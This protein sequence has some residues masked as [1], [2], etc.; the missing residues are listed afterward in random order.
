M[1]EEVQDEERGR[2][3]RGRPP[4]R[5]TAS[6]SLREKK[7]KLESSS[8]RDESEREGGEQSSAS[9]RSREDTMAVAADRSASERGRRASSFSADEDGK[10]AVSQQAS[11]G[12]E[13]REKDRTSSASAGSP[14]AEAPSTEKGQDAGADSTRDEEARK[15]RRERK[16]EKRRQEM[17]AAESL[18]EPDGPK[19]YAFREKRQKRERFEADIAAKKS[20]TAVP[21]GFQ[22]S[23]LEISPDQ[24]QGLQLFVYRKKRKARDERKLGTSGEAGAGGGFERQASTNGDVGGGSGPRGRLGSVGTGTGSEGG[25][26]EGEALPE[27]LQ[28]GSKSSFTLGSLDQSGS[29]DRRYRKKKRGGPGRPRIH[30]IP[31]PAGGALSHHTALGTR[32]VKKLLPNPKLGPKGEGRTASQDRVSGL[33]EETSA[34]GLEADKAPCGRKGAAEA[35]KA[36]GD[37]K[38]ATL[39]DGSRGSKRASVASTGKK[40][41]GKTK[42]SDG[43]D[44]DLE[45]G[46]EV[47]PISEESARMIREQFFQD[48]AAIEEYLP[49]GLYYGDS[50]AEDRD[51]LARQEEAQKARYLEAK[52][53]F[54]REMFQRLF[55]ASAIREESEKAQQARS[56]GGRESGTNEASQSSPRA[57]GGEVD[58]ERKRPDAAESEEKDEHRRKGSK[59]EGSDCASPVKSRAR[60]AS[61]DAERER[62]PEREDRERSK[63]SSSA[64]EA[65]DSLVSPNRTRER[66]RS[67]ASRQSVA[68]ALRSPSDSLA[69]ESLTEQPVRSPSASSSRRASPGRRAKAEADSACED[70]TAQSAS[71]HEG[72]AA[73]RPGSDGSSS[74]ETD[75]AEKEGELVQKRGRSST[76]GGE[77]PARCVESQPQDTDSRAETNKENKAAGQSRAPY[78]LMPFPS[79]APTA[80][81][82]FSEVLA[83][84]TCKED[85]ET[86]RQA[87]KSLQA[88]AASLMR[89]V[90]HLAESRPFVSR[91]GASAVAF[92]GPTGRQK[93]ARGEDA[94]CPSGDSRSVCPGGRPLGA[95]LSSALLRA[96]Q[97]EAESMEPAMFAVA[98]S[99]SHLLRAYPPSILYEDLP[100]RL[101]LSPA[102][103]ASLARED[104]DTQE[105]THA[106]ERAA[107]PE[108]DAGVSAPGEKGARVKETD[109]QKDEEGKPRDRKSVRPVGSESARGTT[110]T[111]QASGV[112]KEGDAREE[113]AHVT[114]AQAPRGPLADAPRRRFASEKR[115]CFNSLTFAHAPLR[116]FRCWASPPGP[117]GL[118]PPSRPVSW[119]RVRAL[120]RA[121]GTRRLARLHAE[122]QQQGVFY[123]PPSGEWEALSVIHPVFWGTR[124]EGR[125]RA[126]LL[127]SAEDEETDSCDCS[128]EEG[129]GA[130][131]VGASSS[132][133]KTPGKGPASPGAV[134]DP[135]E[136]AVASPLAALAS[137]GSSGGGGLGSVKEG[138]SLESAALPSL[139]HASTVSASGS[140]GPSGG[141]STPSTTASGAAKAI[142]ALPASLPAG[143]CQPFLAARATLQARQEEKRLALPPPLPLRPHCLSADLEAIEKAL[144]S[145]AGG[146]HV[147]SSGE[148]HWRRVDRVL[149]AFHFS[150]VAQAKASPSGKGEDRREAK[151]D[152]MAFDASVLPGNFKTLLEP[153]HFF[154]SEQDLET[155]AQLLDQARALGSALASQSAGT[156]SLKAGAGD[157]AHGKAGSKASPQGGPH[158]GGAASRGGGLQGS[159]T[160]ASGD[161]TGKARSKKRPGTA[162]AFGPAVSAEER[163]SEDRR[164]SPGAFSGPFASGAGDGEKGRKEASVGGGEKTTLM[165]S[166]AS[167]KKLHTDAANNPEV[168]AD[169]RQLLLWRWRKEG[170]SPGPA[171]GPVAVA[172]A[173]D[174]GPGTG[175]EETPDAQEGKERSLEGE[176][177]PDADRENGDVEGRAAETHAKSDSGK[178]RPLPGDADRKE[179]RDGLRE[180]ESGKRR[181]HEEEKR[182]GKRLAAQTGRASTR[183]AGTDFGDNEGDETPTS[184][185]AAT[186]VA[187]GSTVGTAS[188]ELEG[189]KVLGRDKPAGA[190]QGDARPRRNAARS[191][192]ADVLTAVKGGN[193]AGLSGA[194][195]GQ[196]GTPSSSAPG[197]SSPPA[198]SVSSASLPSALSASPA[199]SPST[200]ASASWGQSPF[201]KAQGT[202]SSLGSSSPGALGAAGES[203]AAVALAGVAPGA[204]PLKCLLRLLRHYPLS[205]LAQRLGVHRSTVARWAKMWTRQQIEE[206]GDDDEDEG[207]APVASSASSVRGHADL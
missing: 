166:A 57:L 51:L 153:L 78:S 1:K 59:E 115:L 199:L 79:Q 14:D 96:V 196:A 48:A 100:P 202:V 38:K 156:K 35:H 20:Y 27:T 73:G 103:V 22:L 205:V 195:T 99:L 141:V 34:S 33:R 204:P 24:V 108:E 102:A 62:S 7:E 171:F 29:R 56:E 61:H 111:N 68:S 148:R 151:D 203:A 197:A 17:L 98:S 75:F 80:E 112:E 159:P 128:E 168:E 188:M 90:T 191:R 193:H 127:F 177:E 110:S 123:A 200:S 85:I 15:A 49:F 87:T 173:P 60:E 172:T 106:K 84:E 58:L 3:S 64:D 174:E 21:T 28:S 182:D 13:T 40:R 149:N 37:K 66:R 137:G 89:A 169:I 150:Q 25:E 9:P 74:K 39:A 178:K 138:T 179:E 2:P 183:Q 94:S 190:G 109:T 139:S 65:E 201:S 93:Q 32:V 121:A 6:S 116:H 105:G 113:K 55:L 184:L 176:E 170:A 119:R 132:K 41:D 167:L 135:S 180:D 144:W 67:S 133:K 142:P 136:S 130:K 117:L 131:D 175:D 63:G 157:G 129:R 198:P 88:S 158:T 145:P 16:Q 42:M 45:H 69:Q 164:T 53:A 92:S 36:A 26:A 185:S 104:G 71:T 54:Q 11:D 206:E 107:K 181:K 207:D 147:V 161:S 165:C 186:T 43:G 114:A 143:A 134:S 83:R 70:A 163:K 23:S 19:R 140:S 77:R 52:K 125:K 50:L 44:G 189:E 12:E 31:A 76:S 122:S 97:E 124:G 126:G 160:S 162:D 194:E 146:C 81:G 91:L 4:S 46:R 154:P 95:R 5:G 187:P 8:S 30:P 47:A 152:E 155:Q 18:I 86:R 101:Q 82:F 120:L 10:G 118:F 192:L 72:E